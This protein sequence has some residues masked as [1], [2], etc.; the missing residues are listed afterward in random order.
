MVT[1]RRRQPAPAVPL[2]LTSPVSDLPNC[3]ATNV[4]ALDR[5]GIRT[6]KDLLLNLPFGWESFTEVGGV[7]SLE[8][9]VP[10][11]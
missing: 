9:N 5:L 8:P 10:A 1:V 11:T 6:V 3:S 4:K 2:T 7:G